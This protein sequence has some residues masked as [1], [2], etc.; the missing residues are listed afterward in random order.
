MSRLLFVV[1]TIVSLGLVRTASAAEPYS[2]TGW[3]GG[4]SIGW[5]HSNTTTSQ[6]LS[7][8][9]CGGGGC[10]TQL[11]A[12]NSIAPD[13]TSDNVTGGVQAGYNWRFGQF[14]AGVEADFNYVGMNKTT[15]TSVTYAPGGGAT[16]TVTATQASQSN[17]VGTFRPRVGYLPAPNWL[18]Y[19]TGGLA[20]TDFNYSNNV[21]IVAV[22]GGAPGTQ[23]TFSSSSKPNIGYV[24]GGGFEY[25]WSN[26][27]TVKAEYQHLQFNSVNSLAINTV[28]NGTDLPGASLNSQSKVAAD[29]V[30]FGV[31]WKL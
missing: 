16:K 1:I 23:A 26:K 30:R 7:Q 11:S 31:N 12:V 25:A 14:I 13:L 2:W 6:S 9:N 8:P 22:G 5:S 21:S 15:T 27:M 17:V 24:L 20:V 4:G 10:P 3:Y 28:T 29:I 18:V 19:V